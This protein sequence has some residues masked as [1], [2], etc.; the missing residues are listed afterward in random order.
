MDRCKW[1]KMIKEARWFGWVWVGESS[2]W[3]RR[4]RVVPDQRPLNGRCCCRYL[5]ACELSFTFCD[6]DTVAFSIISTVVIHC[7]LI[8]LSQANLQW[9]MVSVLLQSHNRSMFAISNGRPP[10][11]WSF[12]NDEC[13][14]TAFRPVSEAARSWSY[15]SLVVCVCSVEL[16]R[17][18]LRL[19]RV[20]ASLNKELERQQEHVKRLADDVRQTYL[21]L[22]ILL[23]W[24]RASR[25]CSL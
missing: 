7:M 3:Y 5:F 11:R 14:V 15:N 17:R 22:L 19:E 21:L 10:M 4:T 6:F 23:W 18:V 13:H 20:N 12:D 16:A 8:L 2:F 9:C 24:W 25:Q 1:R